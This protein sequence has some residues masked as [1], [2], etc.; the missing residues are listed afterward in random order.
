[1]QGKLDNKVAIVTGAAGGIGR[2]S[3]LRFA[4]E[5]ARLLVADV[6]EAV[7]ETA[8]LITEEGGQ[9]LSMRVDVTDEKQVTAMVEAAESRLGEL[10]VCFANAG[11]GGT[12][13]SMANTSAEEF[14]R[15]VR[16]NLLG[17]FLTVRAAAAPMVKRGRGS[18]IMTAS[19]A[20]QA[21]NAAGI[22]YSA[23]KA[24]VMS[25]AQTIAM[26]L[27]GTGVRI[28]AICPGLIETN[29]T[30]GM[31]EQARGRGRLDRVGQ[32]CPLAR[33]GVPAEIAGM[34]AFLASDDS[35]Y[36]NG[37]SLTVDGGLNAVHPFVPPK[38]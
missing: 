1:M 31:F 28:N 15:V 13:D 37:Q 17:T 16:V 27:Y 10:S 14:E 21:A 34:A 8:R 35:S 26:D 12:L 30:Q 38:R 6:N 22:P 11:I 36:V 25:L 20:G 23:S 33:Y 24:G 5:G 3:A 9:A 29:M 18:L 32:F 7:E 19:V 2:A 4:A